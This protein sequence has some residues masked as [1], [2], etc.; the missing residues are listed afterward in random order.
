MW[1]NRLIIVFE[2]G[3][4]V[5]NGHIIE[6]SAE[7]SA[8]QIERFSLIFSVLVLNKILA[9][10]LY[11]LGAK[12][13]VVASVCDMSEHSLKSLLRAVERDSPAV[14][15][16]RR[17]ALPTSMQTKR[18]PIIDPPTPPR[19][20]L[21]LDEQHCVIDFGGMG[22]PL[23]IARSHQVHLKT[24]LLS[25]H[26]SDLLTLDSVSEAL[27]LGLHRCRELSS[28]LLNEDVVQSLVD[29]RQGPKN[30]PFVDKTVKIELIQHFCMQIMTGC[31]TSSRT[32][33]ERLNDQSELNV[34]ERAVGWHMSELGL[35]QIKKTLP[36]LIGALKK[37]C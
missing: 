36:T 8:K 27:G 37:N 21:M 10:S 3:I 7:K 11:L 5:V 28:Q 17:C 33:A 13:N 19:V 1:H 20:S 9:F 25:L 4:Q 22:S 31:S 16:D 18:T 34:S 29:K 15:H 30:N 26:Q 24:V 32:L 2:K 14:F 12:R 35:N 23:K 6:F